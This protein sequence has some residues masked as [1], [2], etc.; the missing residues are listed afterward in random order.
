MQRKRAIER[1]RVR[2]P[3]PGFNPNDDGDHMV[4]PR[5]PDGR[6]KSPTCE[7]LMRDM[8]A[9]NLAMGIIDSLPL[10]LAL[11]ATR[12][13]LEELRQRKSGIV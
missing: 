1:D 4:K 8:A 5:L 11:I 3:G 9:K 10:D 2:R 13:K 7:Q 12:R 6:F